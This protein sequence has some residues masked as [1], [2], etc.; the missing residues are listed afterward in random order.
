MSK[1]KNVRIGVALCAWDSI[2]P[3]CVTELMQL[4]AS[5]VADYYALVQ[6]TLLPFARNE[7]VRGIYRDAGPDWTHLWFL[8]QD[9][10]NMTPSVLMRLVSHDVDIVSPLTTRRQP[11]FAPAGCPKVSN[12]SV[13]F[14]DELA[15]P[16]PGLVEC[17]SVGCGGML[18]KREVLDALRETTPD[19][20]VWFMMDREMNRD[21]IVGRID[22]LV[23]ETLDAEVGDGEGAAE[24]AMAKAL[25]NAFNEGAQAYRDG[26]P[27]GEDVSFCRRA[28]EAGFKCYVDCGVLADHIGDYPYNI[29]SHIECVRA[30][31][32]QTQTQTQT[33]DESGPVIVTSGE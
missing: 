7:A 31:Q 22:T 8:D 1:R 9:M 16:E 15:K 6:G 32:E 5:G 11:P 10:A 23:H 27:L 21:A 2:K 14:M 30:E 33:V 3:A 26:R 20:D 19:G 29:Q 25:G 24:A 17:I 18:I 13:V 4:A 12:N 28:I